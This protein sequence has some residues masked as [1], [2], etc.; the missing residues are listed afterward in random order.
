[1]CIE[2]Q[3]EC[4]PVIFLLFDV[5]MGFINL[6]LIQHKVYKIIVCYC[7]KDCTCSNKLIW[8]WHTKGYMTSLCTVLLEKLT[9]SQLRSS[10]PTGLCPEPDETSPILSSCIFKIHFNIIIPSTRQCSKQ[11]ISASVSTKP[12]YSFR[13]SFMHA[14]CPS[15]FFQLFP[16]NIQGLPSIFSPST[17]SLFR[18]T[19]TSARTGSA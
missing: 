4:S 15:N 9:V 5:L 11:S 3:M 7:Y 2:I 16:A 18:G 14:M 19:S 6:F 8:R 17:A 10:L 1:M 13:F 12:L